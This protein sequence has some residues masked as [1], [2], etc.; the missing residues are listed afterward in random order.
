MESMSSI[1]MDQCSNSPWCQCSLRQQQHAKDGWDQKHLQE[2]GNVDP[3]WEPK[4]STK[5]SWNRNQW[6]FEPIWNIDNQS[7]QVPVNPEAPTRPCAPHASTR[8][9]KKLGQLTERG[10]STAA[11]EPEGFKFQWPKSLDDPPGDRNFHEQLGY[12]HDEWLITLVIYDLVSGM[13]FQVGNS[14]GC[15]VGYSNYFLLQCTSGYINCHNIINIIPCTRQFNCLSS[16]F[17]T[18]KLALHSLHSALDNTVDVST[19]MGLILPVQKATSQNATWSMLRCF[20]HAWSMSGAWKIKSQ[21]HKPNFSN[22]METPNKTSSLRHSSDPFP[23][24][25]IHFVGSTWHQIQQILQ[26]WAHWRSLHAL[27]G[28]ILPRIKALVLVVF[29]LRLYRLL[30]CDKCIHFPWISLN[31]TMKLPRNQ[32]NPSGGS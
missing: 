19:K 14:F 3:N 25:V 31:G 23:P 32:S 17:G 1:S 20:I 11:S 21:F 6:I 26:R 5:K 12:S 24:T 29:Y 27:Q 28:P 13:I 2:M 16:T 10:V 8:G 9:S 22:V 15:L 30:P 18:C 4:K 7:V